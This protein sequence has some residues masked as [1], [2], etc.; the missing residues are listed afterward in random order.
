MAENEHGTLP[1]E[2]TQEPET[3]EPLS[4]EEAELIESDRGIEDAVDEALETALGE[5][6]S[7]ESPVI[8]DIS[9]MMDELEQASAKEREPEEPDSR[10]GAMIREIPLEDAP[11]EPAP[12]EP[13]ELL[14]AMIREIPRDAETPDETVPPEPADRVDEMIREIPLE[15]ENPDEAV[16]QEPAN[17]VDEMI[18]EIPLEAETPEE[19]APQEPAERVDEMIREIPLEADAGPEPEESTVQPEEPEEDPSAPAESE[20]ERETEPEETEEAPAR[21]ER[22]PGQEEEAGYRKLGLYLHI[23]FCRS[24]CAYCDFYSTDRVVCRGLHVPS[25]MKAYCQALKNQMKFFSERTTQYNVDTV[26]IGGGTPTAL[27]SYLLLDLVKEVSR[28]YYMEDGYEFTVEMNPSTAEAGMLKRLRRAGVN[29]LSIGLQ[30]AQ[31]NELAALSR[32][33]TLGDF[34]A[35]FQMAR[36]AGFENINIDLMYGIPEQTRD[37]FEESLEFAC[38]MK[39][40]HISMYNLRIEEG[41][42]FGKKRQMLPLPDEDAECAMYF[43]G[44]RY[45]RDHG[46]HQYEISN[47]A[48][49]GKECRH[50]LR[51]W[52][53]DEYIGCGSGAHSY[54]GG[55]RFSIRP[56]LEEF[57][58]LLRSVPKTMP[59]ALQ[60][61]NY[62]VDDREQLTEYLMLRFRLTEGISANGFRERFGA[63]FEEHFGALLEPY[64]RDGY[65][66]RSE[67]NGDVRYAFSPKGMFVSNFI[68]SN[69]LPSEPRHN[70]SFNVTAGEEA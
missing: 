52:R 27:P 3:L 39:P 62:P 29:R 37:S 25:E 64:C 48:R 8:P 20:T 15:S 58:S 57:S 31:N 17:R 33:H 53:G 5:S 34:S 61:E 38:N 7:Y 19:A 68:L 59:A 44:I 60:G 12:Q 56:A 46:Y 30:S 28:D 42:P 4:E 41:T 2:E 11:G 23:P 65:V 45:L 49:P 66:L 35:C 6:D 36:E 50:N 40:E 14:D 1:G 67:E 55:R 16:L 13:T 47:F 51:Y 70:P 43:N 22:E 24:K 21:K 9:Q 18:R 69:I 63:D 32:T 54:F 26:F 10:V